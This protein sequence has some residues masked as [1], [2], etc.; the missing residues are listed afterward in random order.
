MV[1]R[2][3]IGAVSGISH[4][5]FV[6]LV[7]LTL[8]EE[9]GRLSFTMVLGLVY[10]SPCLPIVQSSGSGCLCP[11]APFPCSECHWA[12]WVLLWLPG[13]SRIHPVLVLRD[14]WLPINLDFKP[15]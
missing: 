5:S 11:G 10:C 1:A 14:F 13:D 7:A 9:H 6:A 3:L 2:R 4:W 12:F 8:M 15:I